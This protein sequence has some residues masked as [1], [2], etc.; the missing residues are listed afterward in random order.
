MPE[1]KKFFDTFS[2]IGCARLAAYRN[3]LQSVGF[4]EIEPHAIK[5]Y[6]ANAKEEEKAWGDIT[7]IDEKSLPDFDILMGGFPCQA[8][9]MAGKRLGFADTRGTLV[10]HILRICKEKMPPAILLENVEGLLSHDN[11]RTFRTILNCFSGTEN[12]QSRLHKAENTLPY[13]VSWRVLESVNYGV[14]Q[15]RCRVYI[16][17]TRSDLDCNFQFPPQE[18]SYCAFEDIKL[19]LEN[20]KILPQATMNKLRRRALKWNA[21]AACIIRD[22]EPLM[23]ICKST[24][25]ESCAVFDTSIDEWRKIEDVEFKRCQGLPDDYIFPEPKKM[26]GLIGNGMTVDVM[27]KILANL[28]KAISKS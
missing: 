24:K 6:L 3:G 7:K 27:Q 20:P 18:M 13:D 10:F 23:T 12:G 21:A 22:T 17:C 5:A 9:S 4:S 1:L 8:F 15:T 14:P 11:G 25:A 19:R 26:V 2:G 16:A 28:K